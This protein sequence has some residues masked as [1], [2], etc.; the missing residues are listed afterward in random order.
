[1]F[2]CEN[3][4]YID[5]ECQKP[6]HKVKL[7]TPPHNSSAHSV[8]LLVFNVIK[9]IYI[10]EKIVLNMMEQSWKTDLVVIKLI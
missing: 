4:T 5:P 6:Y 3:A 10:F 8:S 1:M 9:S 7:K 2:K